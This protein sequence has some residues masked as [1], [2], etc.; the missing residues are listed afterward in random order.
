M[1]NDFEVIKEF[2][3]YKI[4]KDGDIISIRSGKMLKASIYK[5]RAGK[6]TTCVRLSTNGK[7]YTRS[8]GLLVAKT[9]IPNPKGYKTV[10]HI[11]GDNFNNNINNIEW[12]G[13]RGAAQ[14]KVICVNTGKTYN[15][16]REAAED[17]Y[18]SKASVYLVCNKKMFS[19]SGLVFKYFDEE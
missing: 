12:C 18:I 2:P 6:Y 5:N 3:N 15:G 17:N 19:A 4:N 11:D 13:N 10:K 7:G 1:Y 9:F 16:A 8:I 14:R